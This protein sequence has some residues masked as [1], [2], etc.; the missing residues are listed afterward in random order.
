MSKAMQMYAFVA[1]MLIGEIFWRVQ[2]QKEG[3]IIPNKWEHSFP[4]FKHP[5]IPLL[6]LK[7]LCK[8]IDMQTFVGF[9]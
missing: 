5:K 3:W 8:Q 9:F 7:T 6:T 4:L 2:Q 1:E